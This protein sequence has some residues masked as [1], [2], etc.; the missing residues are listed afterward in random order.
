MPRYRRIN[1]NVCIRAFCSG[2]NEASVTA[3]KKKRNEYR[4]GRY[5]MQPECRDIDDCDG[6]DYIG[7]NGSVWRLGIIGC[8]RKKESKSEKKVGF[9]H[10]PRTGK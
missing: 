3:G 7:D 8:N 10:Q 5:K 2:V 1:H 6:D 4:I 9:H